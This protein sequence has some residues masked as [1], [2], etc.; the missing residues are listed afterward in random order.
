[1]ELLQD[2]ALEKRE[3]FLRKKNIVF[4]SDFWMSSFSQEIVFQSLK[5]F[6]HLSLHPR[7]KIKT[8]IEL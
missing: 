4:M 1:M 7:K 6:R 3:N 2:K 5:S 8:N